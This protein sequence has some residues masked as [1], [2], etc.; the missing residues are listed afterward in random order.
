VDKFEKVIDILTEELEK[1]VSVPIPADELENC[2]KEIVHTFPLRYQ[3]NSD[4]ASLHSLYETMGV[5]WDFQERLISRI[6][7]IT[8]E[9][10]R[11]V[12]EKYFRNPVLVI[13]RPSP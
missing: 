5:G 9:E 4:L 1:V 11:A 3:T 7:R 13:S 8:S 6:Q 10:V 12:A 2:K